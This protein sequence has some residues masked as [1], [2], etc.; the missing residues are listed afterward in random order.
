MIYLEAVHITK[1]YG[2]K[3]LF[4]D[5]NFTISEGQK[6]ALVARNGTGKT[7]LFRILSGEEKSEGYT[8]KLLISKN[9]RVGILTQE[10]KFDPQMTVLEAALS[11]E[12]PELQA[13]VA[14][15]KALLDVDNHE[16]LKKAT[17]QMDALK[18]WDVD[19][20]LKEILFKLNLDDLKALMGTLSG[21]Q[22]KR[23]ALANLIVQDADFL[24]MDEPTNHLDIDMIEWLESYL[25]K[26]SVTLL[27]VTHDRY[28]LDR[29]CDNIL[30][31]EGGKLYKHKGGYGVYLENK[32]IREEVDGAQLTRDKKLLNK[33]LT[34]LRRQPKARST[35]AKSRIDGFYE[36]KEKTER[37]TGPI[38]IKIS[39]KVERLGSKILEAEY[40]SKS[41]GEKVL[42]KDF[43]YKFKKGEKVGVVGPNGIG[44]STFIKLLT[45]NLKPDSGKVVVGVNTKFGYYSQDGLKVDGDKRVIDVVRDIA[46]YIPM[47]SG[48][49]MTAEQLLERFMFSRKH[50]QVYISQLS[51]GELR[52]L[53]LMTVLMQNPNF[54]ILDEP[55]NDLDII[56]LN[57]LE[58][59]LEQYTG[60]VLVVTHDRYFMDKIVDHLFIF[61]GSGK[62]KDFNGTYTEYRDASIK[63]AKASAKNSTSVKKAPTE[64]VIS[65]ENQK[66]IK[67]LERDIERLHVQKK[68]LTAKFY[69]ADLSQDDITALS[70]KLEALK[71]KIDD[72]E[73]AWMELME[74]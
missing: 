67:N 37:D 24:I 56:T 11:G 36:L 4:E 12:I 51:G 18:A 68:E 46:D 3:V 42:V 70:E 2:E 23:V 34:W 25:T 5:L 43:H 49:D 40:I 45:G 19:S 26:P 17:D 44:K 69:E 41:F 14:Y 31:L 62:I 66:K 1:T 7:S 52:R 21:G 65:Y 20:R 39:V 29:V 27:M 71:E 60:C 6:I 22:V 50:Q 47:S 61:E 13:V 9:I 15:E 73:M 30:E 8:S 58:E 10:P 28:F 64:T 72:K 63:A 74:G 16:A 35:K 53:Y 33:E 54:L 55:T 59:F 38:D 48:R 57:I 32:A